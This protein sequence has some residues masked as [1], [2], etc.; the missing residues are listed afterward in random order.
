[1]HKVQID[2]GASGVT[3]TQASTNTAAGLA[4]TVKAKTWKIP[5]YSKTDDTYAV[6]GETITGTTSSKTAVVKQIISPEPGM[7]DESGFLIIDTLSGNFTKDEAITGDGAGSFAAYVRAVQSR[8]KL[9]QACLITVENAA[10]RVTNGAATPVAGGLGHLVY[11]DGRIKLQS[12]DDI[13]SFRV[14]SNV[15][16]VHAT[17]NITPTFG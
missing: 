1:M 5:Y 2:V 4:E 16:G 8:F 12:Q 10:V 9:A 3:Q 7:P 13:N 17:L 6:V 14:I 15:A 11:P